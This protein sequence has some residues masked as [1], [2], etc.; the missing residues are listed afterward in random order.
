MW[1]MFYLNSPNPVENA[2]E[3]H[4]QL[5]M[6]IPNNNENSDVLRTLQLELHR[7]K[8]GTAIIKINFMLNSAE[9]GI[10]PAH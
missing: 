3:F 9:H 5:L 1:Q 2:C 8:A 6:K 7:Q 4:L 10:F